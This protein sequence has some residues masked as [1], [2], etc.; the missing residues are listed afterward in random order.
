[1]TESWVSCDTDTVSCDTEERMDSDDMQ[2]LQLA[3]F[4]ERPSHL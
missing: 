2:V 3:H 4:R 1:M